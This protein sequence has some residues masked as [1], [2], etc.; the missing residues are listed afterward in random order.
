M[1]E[2]TTV[3]HIRPR[4]SLLRTSLITFAAASVPIFGALYWYSA[5]AGGWTSVLAVQLVVTAVCVVSYLLQLRVYAAVS[6]GVL[7]GNGIYSPVVRVPLADI[8]RVVLTQVYSPGASDTTTQ[9]TA[10][11]EGD[12]CL[13]RLRGH[14]WHAD[15]LRRLAA[16]TGAPVETDDEAISEKEF[17]A[18]FPG[19]A[20]WFDGRPWLRVVL[21]AAALLVSVAVVAFLM[22]AV[23][24]PL[25]L[26]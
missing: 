10:V 15:D 24:V 19:S 22:N 11:D 21:I 6:G 9:W 3:V 12:R 23:G 1:D 17:F 2:S 5:S 14:Y 13:F 16:A 8:R 4:R 7:H 18:R 20:Y 25:A 26:R